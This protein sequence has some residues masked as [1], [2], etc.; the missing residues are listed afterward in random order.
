MERQSVTYVRCHVELFA[1]VADQMHRS[2][3][4]V[5]TRKQ[6]HYAR[7]GVWPFCHWVRRNGSQT[8]TKNSNR[9]RKKKFID[10]HLK[11]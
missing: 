9:Y 11:I 1:I 7:R 8:I 4:S 6:V 3:C 5:R 10:D 2:L